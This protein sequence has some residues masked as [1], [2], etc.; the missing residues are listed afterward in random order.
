MKN[1]EREHPSF[2]RGGVLG[3]GFRM[4]PGLEKFQFRL[5]AAQKDLPHLERNS[6][7]M[8][9]KGKR[10]R[11]TEREGRG[12]WN[13]CKG[14]PEAPG[15]EVSTFP[16][17]HHHFLPYSTRPSLPTPHPLALPAFQDSDLQI[18]SLAKMLK[19]WREKK[20][21]KR[22]RASLCS[23]SN[24][25]EVVTSSSSLVV[26]HKTQR[27]CRSKSHNPMMQQQHSRN[28]GKKNLEDSANTYTRPLSSSSLSPVEITIQRP[29]LWPESGAGEGVAGLD[30]VSVQM[31][32]TFVFMN[33]LWMNNRRMSHDLNDIHP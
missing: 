10:K 8:L 20:K 15:V 21:K 33:N 24:H 22:R 29:P 27:Q 3:C 31:F 30:A 6:H 4:R 16:V 25:G 13:T 9:R 5:T 18:P 23:Y 28:R 7:G 1:V 19:M 26:V 12:W 2:G 11:E 17:H 14:L 32:R